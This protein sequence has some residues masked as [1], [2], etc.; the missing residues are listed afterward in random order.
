MSDVTALPIE[1]QPLP[2]SALYLNKLHASRL[3]DSVSDFNK[4]ALHSMYSEGRSVEYNTLFIFLET[5][6]TKQND[7]CDFI[8]I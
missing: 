6:Q 4:T 1:P 8:D 3:P 7:C 5:V 2:V